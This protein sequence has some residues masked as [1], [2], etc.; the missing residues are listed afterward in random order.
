[1]QLVMERETTSENELVLA[2]VY[3]GT[4]AVVIGAFFGL[5]QVLSRA[6][7]VKIPSWFDYY[8]M[9]SAHGT[10]MVLIFT[11]FYVTGLATFSSYRSIPRPRSLGLAWAAWA[12]MLVGA[13]MMLIEIFSGNATVLYTFYAPL[14][15]SPWFYLGTTLLIVGTWLVAIDV[16]RDI[17]WWRREHKGEIVPLPAFTAATTFVM[18][19]VGTLGVVI[20][21]I[22]F[23]LPWSFG[24]HQDINVELTRLLFWYFGHP[25]VYFW[26]MGAYM[27]WYNL[28]PVYIKGNVYSD[29]LTRLSF[30]LLMLLSAP[31]GLHHQFTEPGIANGWKALQ[32]ITTYGVAIPSLF[33]AFSVFAGF[34]LWAH[35]RGKKGFW[36]TAMALP[37]NNPAFAG[38]AYGMLLFIL[39]GFTGLVNGSYSMDTL[40]HNTIWVPAHFHV[41]VAGPVA[42]TFIASSYWLVPKLTGRELWKPNLALWQV[43]LWFVG[44]L[45]FSI[46]LHIAGLMGEPRRTSVLDYGGSAIAAAWQPF[47]VAGAIGG[48]ILFIS[49]I[50]FACV[51][52][53]TLVHN[54]KDEPMDAEFAKP[55]EFSGPTPPWVQSIFRWGLVSLVLA[56]LFWAGPFI[57]LLNSAVHL[58]PGMKTW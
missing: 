54:R 24:A 2:H 29:G 8:R 43:R 27:V 23:L 20:E 22:F 34:E 47:N 56:I 16:F 41:T 19:I 45:I 49:A 52:I 37:W 57:Q 50:L 14:K 40:I 38:A 13:L 46:A 25:L 55:S 32:T 9:L 42:L 39:G 3:T 15:A 1:M 17:F 4:I 10:L 26:I 7:A 58:A 35:K 51:A 53:G 6:D 18:W 36:Q 33:T 48:S 28:V 44:M 12:V 21:E 31:V 30:I 5:M 11:T